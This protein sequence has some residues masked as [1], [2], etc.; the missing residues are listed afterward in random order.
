MRLT[1]SQYMLAKQCPKAIWLHKNNP[2]AV[3]RDVNNEGLYE[4]GRIVGEYAQML[5]PG[6]VL[7][8]FAGDAQKAVV[9]TRKLIEQGVHT[10][11]EAAFSYEDCFAMCD[12][13]CWTR[14]GWEIY[15][16]KSSTE[17]KPEYIQ[18]VLFQ[19][20]ILSSLRMDIAKVNI[21]YINNQY[22]RNG[23]LKPEELFK[24]EDVTTE[25]KTLS[26]N[27]LSELR[28]I[29]SILAEQDEPNLGIGEYCLKPYECACKGYCWSHIPEDSVF[30]LSRV[31]T[32]LKFSLY[33]QGVITF[34][35]IAASGARLSSQAAEIQIRSY[36]SGEDILN[37][38]GIRD[39]LNTIYFPL[40]FL[41]FET[42][43]QPIPMF[44]GL[45]PYEQIP[46]QYSLHYLEKDGAEL[47][48][49]EFLAKEGK[50][51]RRELGERLVNDIPKDVCV[52]AYNMQFEKSVI[53]RLAQ[54]FKDLHDHLMNIHENMVDLMVPFQK[55]HCYMKEM[56]GSYSIK[57]VLPALFPDDGELD[58]KRLNISNGSV[59]MQA[60]AYLHL[61]EPKEIGQIRKDL[62]E[63][64][65]LDTLAMVRVWEKLKSFVDNY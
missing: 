57:H 42:F 4:T 7:V 14:N 37:K 58:Y 18:D 65:K 47:K 44:D 32:S 19:Y 27:I 24:I 21:V 56:K 31:K 13:L 17:L 36:I 52:M 40:Y 29:I 48:H 11:Y 43:Q 50:D 5:F 16:V 12:I 23:K 51:P 30:S 46:S 2:E 1:K 20:Y 45:K 9:E 53:V 55:K 54:Q 49:K 59:A 33:K 8:Q 39:F 38:E 61:K 3:E 15:E 6:G 64:C 25:V 10:I 63:Y 62:L 60:F 41:D 34:E 28:D 35:E 22:E 26:E